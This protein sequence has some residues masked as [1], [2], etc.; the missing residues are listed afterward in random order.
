[1]KPNLFVMKKIVL[2]IVA[3][4]F[5]VTVC[6]A[7][8]QA[9]YTLL[10]VYTPYQMNMEKLNGKVEKV[11]ET[12]YWAIPDA[13]SYKKGQKMTKNQL[14]SLGY[15]GDFE[16]TFDKAGD[17]VSCAILKENKKIAN[18]WELKKENNVLVKA[19]N[20]VNDT[21]KNYDLLKCDKNGNVIEYDNY[22]ATVDT[23]IS[24]GVVV[25]TPKGDTLI[26]NVFNYKGDQTY[27]LLFL[28]NELKQCTGYQGYNK[29]NKYSG[30]SE[31]K[32]DKQGK[33]SELIFYDKDKKPT[34]ENTFINEYDSRGNWVRQICMDKKGFVVI[35]E[36]VYKY[37]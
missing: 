7:Q 24:R 23:L 8:K 2:F 30:G 12:N 33:L 17:L 16:A 10:G 34:S 32:F 11:V 15:T 35:G 31:I 21:L 9:D 36:R 18:K 4:V 25:R 20:T 13:G 5:T 19:N 37:Y 27:K 29:D 1:M 6:K 14:D 28:F 3:F 26:L 22:K